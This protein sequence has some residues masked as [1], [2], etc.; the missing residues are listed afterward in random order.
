MY[1]QTSSAAGSGSGPNSEVA[2]Y[3]RTFKGKPGGT[4]AAKDEVS[5]SKMREGG[6][7]AQAATTNKM[8]EAH[9]ESGWVC[10]PKHVPPHDNG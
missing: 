5:R 6:L 7:Y 3:T 9:V 1:I 4:K 8:A 10:R 2:D